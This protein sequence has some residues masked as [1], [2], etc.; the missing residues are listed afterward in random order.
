MF[1]RLGVSEILLIS[2]ICVLAVAFPSA[3]MLFLSKLSKRIKTIEEN[4]KEKE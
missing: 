1:F 3:V 2:V 4:L